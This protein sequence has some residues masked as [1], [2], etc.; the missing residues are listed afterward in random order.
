MYYTYSHHAETCALYLLVSVYC[1]ALLN[2]AHIHR[3]Q[4]ALDKLMKKKNTTTLSLISFVVK[5]FKSKLKP[6]SA[7]RDQIHINRNWHMNNV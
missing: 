7:R 3:T 6:S 4:D 5:C 2:T 1:K